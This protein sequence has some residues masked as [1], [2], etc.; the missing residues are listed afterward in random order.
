M[1]IYKI[2]NNINGRMYIGSKQGNVEAT[3]YYYGS[4]T[5]IKKA[6]EKYGKHNFSKDILFVLDNI[7]DMKAKEIEVLTELD[8]A[9]SLQYYNCHNNY[10]GGYIPEAY[11]KESRAKI[12]KA[13]SKRVLSDYQRSCTWMNT[14]EVNAKKHPKATCVHCG[15]KSNKANITRWHNDNCKYRVESNVSA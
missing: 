3:Q 15:K 10:S 9:S 8:C 13:N 14:P 6:I 4:G 11:S 12:G 2:T 1:Y 5:V 7:E